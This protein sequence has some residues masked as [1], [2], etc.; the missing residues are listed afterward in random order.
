M[1]VLLIK[2]GK[3]ILNEGVGWRDLE[4]RLKMEPNTNFL[5]RAAP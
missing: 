4:N 1:Q 5:L 2:D 3:I